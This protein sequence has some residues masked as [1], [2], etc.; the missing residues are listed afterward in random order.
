[1]HN[2]PFKNKRTKATDILE[3]IHTDVNGP[4]MITGYKGEKNF[5]SFIDDYSK[6]CKVYCIS[7]KNQ[8]YDC[9]V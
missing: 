2:V 8:V 3:I 1:M 9:F 7:S 6:L 4:H 5:V